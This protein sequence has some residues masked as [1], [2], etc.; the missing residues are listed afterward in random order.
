MPV[1]VLMGMAVLIVYA[2]VNQGESSLF[3]MLSDEERDQ[4][5]NLSDSKA[6]LFCIGGSFS[7]VI[8][9]VLI[10]VFSMLWLIEILF[11]PIFI[12]LFGMFLLDL[13]QTYLKH[14]QTL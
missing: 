4:I 6:A 9:Y 14:V 11:L 8:L 2:G 7:L 5:T 12:L 1:F 13:S 3:N 10:K